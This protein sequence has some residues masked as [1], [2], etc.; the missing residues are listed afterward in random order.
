[1]ES[2]RV[3]GGVSIE[4]SSP[5]S[6]ATTLAILRVRTRR[7]TRLLAWLGPCVSAWLAPLDQQSSIDGGQAVRARP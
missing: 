5:V 7:R 3:S 6:A 4:I 1:V 2:S